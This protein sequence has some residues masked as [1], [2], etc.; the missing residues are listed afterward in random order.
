[1]YYER[2][3]EKLSDRTKIDTD[4]KSNPPERESPTARRAPT[5]FSFPHTHTKTYAH[6]KK[7]SAYYK[8]QLRRPNT[9]L[10]RIYRLW[11]PFG[12][13]DHEKFLVYIRDQVVEAR[14][15][16]SCK[17]TSKQSLMVETWILRSKHEVKDVKHHPQMPDKFLILIDLIPL[18]T[19]HNFR[20]L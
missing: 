12:L 8:N 20:D 15:A 3:E 7:W 19:D 16:S 14:D 17:S 9:R 6:T 11:K 10:N 2:T 1:M 5:L 13:Q 18:M 4:A